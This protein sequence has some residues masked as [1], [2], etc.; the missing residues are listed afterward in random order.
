MPGNRK[1]ETGC[2]CAKHT[3]E[4]RRKVTAAARKPRKKCL[5]GC[6][7]A[8]HTPKKCLDDCRCGKHREIQQEQIQKSIDAMREKARGFHIHTNGY[9]V[10]TNQEHPL[11]RGGRLYD[12]RRVLYDKIGPGP[13]RCY[14]QPLSGCKTS[15]LEWD[16][17]HV[18]HIDNDVTNNAPENL[19]ASCNVCNRSRSRS[20]WWREGGT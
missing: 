19:V 3:E 12:H 10:L 8:R 7:C 2:L 13:H 11:A 9:I 4:Y 6:L 17:I 15:L 1:C 14:W 5:P 18:D 20:L 16:D